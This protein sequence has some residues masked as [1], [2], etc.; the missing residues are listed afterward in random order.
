MPGDQSR[1][2]R[3]GHHLK[4]I[5]TARAAHRRAL[6]EQLQQRRAA[7]AEY[8][9]TH[10]VAQPPPDLLGETDQPD[11]RPG[12]ASPETGRRTRPRL[13]TYLEDKA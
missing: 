11:G 4:D 2:Q 10:P 9:P 6:R 1:V 8:L 13:L 12:P 7:V 5:Q 3:A